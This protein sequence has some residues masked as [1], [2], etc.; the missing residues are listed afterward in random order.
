VNMNT[1]CRLHQTMMETELVSKMSDVNA[2]FTHFPNSHSCLPKKT[3]L[4]MCYCKTV[5]F[6]E[7]FVLLFH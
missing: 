5:V 2:I 3:P 6:C 1:V 7:L 4:Q